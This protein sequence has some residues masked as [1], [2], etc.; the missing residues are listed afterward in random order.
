MVRTIELILGPAADEPVRR[1]G[2]ADGQLL[3]G[4]ARP[5]ALRRRAEQHPA[6]PAQSRDQST[7]KDPRQLHW[8]KESAKLDL[9]DIDQADEDTFNRIL[10]HAAAAATI[11]IRNGRSVRGLQTNCMT[12][13]TRGPLRR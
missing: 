6:R 4:R 8:A 3:Y 13:A 9:D 11:R 7:I 2:H 1:V 12:D 5:D 10:W